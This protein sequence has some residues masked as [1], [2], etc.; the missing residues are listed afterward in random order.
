LV[1]SSFEDD[2]DGGDRARKKHDEGR[3][4]LDDGLSPVNSPV[5]PYI[6]ET[7][8]NGDMLLSRA[9][10]NQEPG[11]RY[12]SHDHTDSAD[13]QAIAPTA[14]ETEGDDRLSQ[15]GDDSEDPQSSA[16]L[17]LRAERIL[18]NA[19]KRLDVSINPHKYSENLQLM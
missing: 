3:H 10:E 7:L 18:A 17:S 11:A 8:P 14:A 5:R 13:H 6:D 1:I 15:M 16:A 9:E 19:K 2:D 4:V 12:K